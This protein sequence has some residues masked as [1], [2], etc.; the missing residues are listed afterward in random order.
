MKKSS[1]GA[2]S[3]LCNIFC[4]SNKPP[5]S[6]QSPKEKIRKSKIYG[7]NKLLSSVSQFFKGLKVEKYISGNMIFTWSTISNPSLKEH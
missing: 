2:T 6:N 3:L 7:A 1:K 4:K 5:R